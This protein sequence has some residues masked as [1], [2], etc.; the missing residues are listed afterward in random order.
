MNQHIDTSKVK[1]DILLLSTVKDLKQKSEEK[2]LE[3]EE[4]KKENDGLKKEFE[5]VRQQLEFK[6]EKNEKQTKICLDEM[7]KNETQQSK[8][9][10][11]LETFADRC[12]KIHF[13]LSDKH[14]RRNNHRLTLFEQKYDRNENVEEW[15]KIVEEVNEDENKCVYLE[16]LKDSVN[17]YKETIY[18]P[19]YE[20]RFM[21]LCYFIPA[22]VVR[23]RFLKIRCHHGI[24]RIHV[25]SC[26]SRE[27]FTKEIERIDEQK[28]TYKIQNNDVCSFYIGDFLHVVLL[29]HWYKVYLLHKR[30]ENKKLDLPQGKTVKLDDIYFNYIVNGSVGLY[31]N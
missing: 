15:N 13:T 22:M 23:N 7:K 21:N 27:E 28:T 6:M 4:L 5:N 10:D 17:Q 24:N 18:S 25:K 11:D 29:G 2:D 1:H 3:I 14:L 30:S 16:K 31:F 8:K 26:L 19:T 12:S 20:Q 9:I